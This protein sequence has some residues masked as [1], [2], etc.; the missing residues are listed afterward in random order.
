MIAFVLE[1]AKK[2]EIL[3]SWPM[4]YFQAARENFSHRVTYTMQFS[5]YNV[6]FRK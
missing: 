2:F 5:L 3:L 1:S 6:E 4:D